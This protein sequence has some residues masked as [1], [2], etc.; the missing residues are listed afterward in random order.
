[1]NRKGV[2]KMISELSLTLRNKYY[3]IRLYFKNWNTLN[4]HK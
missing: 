3:R 4:L 1:M 2:I